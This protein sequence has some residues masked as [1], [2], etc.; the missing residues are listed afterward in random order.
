M[1]SEKIN[2]WL[3]IVGMVGIMASLIFVGV[4]V[5]QTQR[6]GE[7]QEATGF[8]ELALELRGLQLEHLP[9]WRK[10]CA[11]EEL[12]ADE[13]HAGALLFKAYLEFNFV[14]G[15]ATQVNMMQQEHNVF[16]HRL[17]A[18]LHR[19]PGFATMMEMNNVWSREGEAV[20][21]DEKSMIFS[22]E[23]SGRLAELQEL[24]P[25]PD[26]DLMWCGV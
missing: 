7:G 6:A 20:H 22:N 26:Y 3:Q 13:R 17:A 24:E 1:K 19:Y 11:G 21:N 5:R 15:V 23:V 16:A 9:V 12:T 18:N 8:I 14:G 2:D 25:N 4:Q 10:V